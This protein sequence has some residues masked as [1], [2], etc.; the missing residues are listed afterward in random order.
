MLSQYCLPQAR[1]SHLAL[2]TFLVSLYAVPSLGK[3]STNSRL[4]I[5]LLTVLQLQAE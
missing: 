3:C 2:L 5:N 4:N 1:Y